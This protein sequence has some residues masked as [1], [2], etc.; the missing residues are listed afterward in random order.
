[1]ARP[2]SWHGNDS[3]KIIHN[4]KSFK[5]LK[6]WNGDDSKAKRLC[7]SLSWNGLERQPTLL[8]KSQSWCGIET[9]SKACNR[10]QLWLGH[11]IPVPKV[12][13]FFYNCVQ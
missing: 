9:F 1:M 6:S 3:Y 12:S 4:Q 13:F 10:L 11:G 2:L 8:H 5:R 7:K